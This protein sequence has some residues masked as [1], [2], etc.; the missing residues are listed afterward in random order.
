MIE[1]NDCVSSRRDGSAACGTHGYWPPATDFF[2]ESLIDLIMEQ[3][4]HRRLEMVEKIEEL[5]KIRAEKAAAMDLEL[6]AT[7]SGGA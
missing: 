2:N 7:A 4:F 3:S 1:C 5:T 6:V